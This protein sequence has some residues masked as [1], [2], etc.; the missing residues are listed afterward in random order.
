MNSRVKD[1]MDLS[2]ENFF[3]KI[4]EWENLL[5]IK[6]PQGQI[7]SLSF[8][9]ISASSEK[10][11]VTDG[12]SGINYLISKSG[13]LP[14]WKLSIEQGGEP[15]YLG[16]ASSLKNGIHQAEIFAQSLRESLF[17]D[18]AGLAGKG[19]PVNSFGTLR[20]DSCDIKEVEEKLKDLGYSESNM[21]F[22]HGK[23][24]VIDRVDNKEHSNYGK[25][26]IQWEMQ[27]TPRD[28]VE[29][30]ETIKSSSV[31]AIAD[32]AVNADKA[33][34]VVCLNELSGD[35]STDRDFV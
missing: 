18:S 13:D 3:N 19:C 33:T 30:I 6:G 2:K 5:A 8:R 11:A 15:I 16:N 31:E 21:D 22:C 32:M 4:K 1:I 29:A 28:F 12:D 24:Y 35:K 17:L 14:S 25:K 7:G 10:F 26:F 20:F 34:V 27:K 23:T 9:D